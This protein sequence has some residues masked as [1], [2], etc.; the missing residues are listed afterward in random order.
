MQ[1]FNP[2]PMA[3]NAAADA[4]IETAAPAVEQITAQPP[5]T[6][7]DPAI[8]P[9]AK[10]E[11]PEGP[12]WYRKAIEKER[13]R[14]QAL[15]RELETTRSQQPQAQPQTFD[16]PQAYFDHVRTV[17]RLERSEDRFIDKRGEQEL[18]E[19]KEW[20]KTRPDIERWAIPQRDPWGAAYQ[21][22]QREKLSAEIGDDPNAWR[23]QERERLRAELLAEATGQGAAP[24]AMSAPRLPQSA[25]SARSATPPPRDQAGQFSPF[26]NKF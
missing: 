13:K 18:E 19:V 21:Q 16:D 5:Q 14:A 17:D 12:F 6:T 15:E 22:Y 3:E 24:A 11:H 26:K 1:D 10:P 2:A 25:A 8:A 4:T 23:E 9:E 20:L 7:I